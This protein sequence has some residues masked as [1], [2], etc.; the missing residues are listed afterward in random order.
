V[1]EWCSDNWQVDG[2]VASPPPPDRYYFVN[3]TTSQSFEVRGGAWNDSGEVF[4]R[5]AFRGYYGVPDDRY[6]LIGFRVVR[7]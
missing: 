7:R 1:F 3:D 4:F 5:C 2:S 6:N